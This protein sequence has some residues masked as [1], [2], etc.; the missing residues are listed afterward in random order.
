MAK[1]KA[2]VELKSFGVY[3]KWN[4]E[5]KEL[6]KLIKYTDKIP[7]ELGTEFGYI[8][9]IKKAKGLKINFIIDHPAISAEGGG[10]MPAFKGEEYVN[11]NNYFFFLGDMVWE[12]AK[13]KKGRWRLRTYIEG[14]LVYDKTLIVGNYSI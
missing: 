1:K 2:E 12:P 13:E 6:P 8:L 5:K 11:S 10:K 4:K 3:S 7:A 14:D 9:N